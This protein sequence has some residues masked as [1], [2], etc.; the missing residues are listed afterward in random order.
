MLSVLAC[1]MADL[2]TSVA[3]LAR[4]GALAVMTPTDAIMKYLRLTNSTARKEKTRLERLTS[5]AHHLSG[6]PRNPV[7]RARH[8][9]GL[10]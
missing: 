10:P 3:R 5:G 4:L 2:L 7:Q 9:A 1:M 6:Y 8:K